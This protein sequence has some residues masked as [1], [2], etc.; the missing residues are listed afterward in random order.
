M[1]GGLLALLVGSVLLRVHLFVRLGPGGGGL[2]F[3]GHR[4]RQYV[5][6]PDQGLTATG[7]RV[8]GQQPS[9]AAVH[10]AQSSLE[11]K[12]DDVVVGEE[13]RH[14]ALLHDGGGQAQHFVLQCDSGTGDG[15]DLH[16]V[17]LE[18]WMGALLAVAD[19]Q[20]VVACAK[21]S[22]VRR[23]D[24]PVAVH[25]SQAS[26]G[27]PQG[28]SEG[29]G[30]RGVGR[31]LAGMGTLDTDGHNLAAQ[32]RRP[33]L[34]TADEQLLDS[35]LRLAAAAGV[36]PQVAT[37]VAAARRS[38]SV[39]SLV[40]LGVDQVAAAVAA[41]LPRRPTVAVVSDHSTDDTVWQHAVAVGAEQVLV[42]PDA[43]EH[44]L[45][46]L[47]DGGD[48]AGTGA[49][50]VAVVGGCGGAGASTFSAALALTAAERGHPALLVDADPLGGGIDLVV[51]REDTAGLRWPDL[52]GASGRLSAPALRQALPQAEQHLSVLSWG[53]E[54]LSSVPAASMRAVVQAGQRGHDVVV[55]DLPRHLD[56]A[57]EEALIRVDQVLVVV[58]AQVRAVAAAHRVVAALRELSPR[59]HAVVRG[60][61]PTGLDGLLVAESL[62]VP[63]AAEM[64]SERGLAESLDLGLGPLRRRRGPLRACALDVLNMLGTD[65][66]TGTGTGDDGVAA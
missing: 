38:W 45:A 46:V 12:P 26:G 25:R 36:T 48:S 65:T 1:L 21:A 5:G 30:G 55:V 20:Q 18:S 13:A 39:A 17:L 41:G 19:S 60:P 57:S 53:R 6:T 8:V 9:G 56:A 42:L 34:V 3:E 16:G 64:R 14:H 63:L 54:D 10:R 24:R 59:L 40:V 50:T 61:G 35:L 7:E 58:P 11:A 43:A 23:V 15:Q 49:T 33:L 62:Q 27:R 47:G 52:A 31:S 29:R 51:G 2:L 37:D 66:G 32:V 22:P 28:R 4:L 44:L